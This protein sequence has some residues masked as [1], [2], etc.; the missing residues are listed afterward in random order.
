MVTLYMVCM[1]IDKLN[2]TNQVNAKCIYHI[3][4][5]HKESHMLILVTERRRD[6]AKS[7]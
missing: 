7:S 1:Y 6:L 2:E 3:A 4:I 5:T